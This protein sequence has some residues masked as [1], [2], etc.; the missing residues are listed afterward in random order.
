MNDFTTEE[1][2]LLFTAIRTQ[3]FAV[4]LDSDEKETYA[5]IRSKLAHLKATLEVRNEYIRI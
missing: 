2:D 5:L 1:I 4:Y 3:I